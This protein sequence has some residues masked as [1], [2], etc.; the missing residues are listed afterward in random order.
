MS[1]KISP[2]PHGALH[3]TGSHTTQ[4]QGEIYQPNCS[5][6]HDSGAL[7]GVVAILV[8]IGMLVYVWNKKE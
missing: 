4:P 2:F 8:F 1:P 3:T 5:H 7:G 6:K